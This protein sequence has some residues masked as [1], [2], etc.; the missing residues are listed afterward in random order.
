[1][2]L[3]FYLYLEGQFAVAVLLVLVVR[4]HESLCGS[5]YNQSSVLLYLAGLREREGL[6][7]ELKDYS[8]FSGVL[9]LW[10][11]EKVLLLRI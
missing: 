6:N 9:K 8:V 4:A 10:Q 1:M 11:Q 2:L 5:H 3:L 7:S